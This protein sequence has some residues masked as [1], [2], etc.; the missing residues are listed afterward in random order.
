[1]R[2]LVFLFALALAGCAPA[3]SI[4]PPDAAPAALPLE[5]RWVRTA[6]EHRATFLQTYR[7]AT[8]H[9]RAMAD[10]LGADWAVIMDADETILDN[11]LYQR[12]RAR[13]GLGYTPESWN[14]WVREEAAPALP[15]AVA[16]AQAV[17]ALGGRVV[18]VTNREDVV[19]EPTRDNLRELGVPFAAVLCQQ[20]GVGDKEPRFEAVRLGEGTGL[21]PLRVVMWVGDNIGD[22][23]GL[24][25]D[26]R[27]EGA[28]AF[29]RFGRSYWVL[30]NPM[31]G[32]WTRNLDPID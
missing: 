10:T 20:N 21:P 24:S 6:A 23:P 16:F 18:V 28:A 17:E 32:S 12:R 8:E 29:D 4:A 25:Q 9:L 14:D 13:Q 1:M 31:Y 7:G 19:C 26:V 5:I 27:G 30:P 2:Y 11:S 22:F 15:G 3:F